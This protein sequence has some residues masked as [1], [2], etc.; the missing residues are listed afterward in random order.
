M[1]AKIKTGDEVIVL[2]GKD[3]GKKGKVEKVLP[4]EGRAL[5]AGIN[6]VKK[7][8]KPSA[9]SA[10]GIIT[11]SLPIDLSNVAVVD[12][13]SGKATRVGFKV[14]DGKKVRFA[15]KSGEVL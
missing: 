5:V 6:Q 15:K 11:K 10:G 4:T 7:H 14:V 8:Q 12:P 9:Q 1:A 13:K 3:K 2:A